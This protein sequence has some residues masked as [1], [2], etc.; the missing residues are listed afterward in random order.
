MKSELIS[1][2]Y[3]IKNKVNNCC[4]IGGSIDIKGRWRRH[5][6]ELKR[7]TH[8]SK[9]LQRAWDEYKEDNFE[10]SIIELCEEKELTEKEQEYLDKLNPSYN[11]SKKGGCVGGRV[12]TQELKLKISLN[13]S[14]RG[15]FGKDHRSS[16][17]IYQYGLDGT[18]LKLW[19]GAKEVKREL[20]ISSSNI[21]VLCQEKTRKTTGKRTIGGFFWTREFLG[22]KIEPIKLHN[23][24]ALRKRIGC[25][26]DENNMVKEFKSQDEADLFF[27]GWKSRRVKY[28]LKHGSKCYNYKWKYL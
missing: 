6:S 25:F 8:H 26:D 3:I 22:E 12:K 21:T 14:C 20:G 27:D 1:G 15:K 17:I 10:F 18:F 28:A 19:Y 2:V 13:H 9:I 4:Y 7:G 11:V 24:D 23:R 16:K 5:K